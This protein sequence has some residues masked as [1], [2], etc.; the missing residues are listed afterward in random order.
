MKITD[1]TT[2][3]LSYD[4]PVPMADAIHFM[5]SRPT[6]LVQVHTDAGIVGLGESAAYGGYLE[7]TEAIV[8]GELRQTILDEDP[9][10]VEKLW[11]RMATRAHQRGRRGMMMMAISGVDIALWDIIG[12]ATKTPLYRLLGAYRHT[13]DAYASAGFYARDKDVHTLEEEVRGY[14]E[15]GFKTI[16]IKVGRNP[17]VMLNPLHDMQAHDYATVSLDEDIERVRAARAAI[18]PGVRL[19]VDANNAWTPSVA[20]KFMRE[21][22]S[23]KIHWLEEP[24]S[25]DDIEGSAAVASQLDTPVAGYETETGLSGFR[26]LITRRAVDI[27][28]PDVIWTGGITE[29]RK[30]AALAQAF[31]LPLIPHVFSSA[32]STIANMHLIASIPNG[33][34]LEF[35]QNPNPLRS[36]LFEEPIEVSTNGAVALPERPGLGVTLNQ[37]TIQRYRIEQHRPDSV[38]KIT[39]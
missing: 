8:L 16:K 26:E 7:S 28:Q 3:K 14:A 34:L 24:V 18:G 29:T 13:L 1:V 2:I 27:V 37:A 31:G 5:P 25:T 22:E 4:L 36:E 20:L 38:L 21:V 23:L 33:G 6:L 15:R 17:D 11:A 10:R 39:S 12:Q 30:V 9:F 32:V 19:A 35:D